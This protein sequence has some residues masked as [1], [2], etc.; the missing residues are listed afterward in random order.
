MFEFIDLLSAAIV[1]GFE[2]LDSIDEHIGELVGINGLNVGQIAHFLLL[3]RHHRGH[4]LLHL[5][6]NHPDTTLVAGR[7]G[8]DAEQVGQAAPE[9]K[10]SESDVRIEENQ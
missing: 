3:H 1:G 8:T 4:H 6:G 2:F 9:R 10:H 7:D 5:L